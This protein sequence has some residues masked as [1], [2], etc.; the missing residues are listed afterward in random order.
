M[1]RAARKPA[2]K[3][4]PRDILQA[5]ADYEAWA[6]TRTPMIA[7]DLEH[8]HALMRA[9]R[10]S[11]FRA[12]F[13]RWAELWPFVCPD[14]ESGPH[15]L[16]VGDLHVENF[17]VWRDA[18]GRLV[19]GV[20]DF[21]EAWEAAFSVDLVRLLA[22]VIL[23]RETA[24]VRLKDEAVAELLRAGWLRAMTKD[25]APFVLSGRHKWLTRLAEGKLKDPRPFWKKME[26]LGPADP[27]EAA[28]APLAVSALQPQAE[29]VKLLH[30]I[31]GL[32]SLGH[33]RVVALGEWLGG[34]IAREAKALTPSAWIWA[35][36]GQAAGAPF[37]YRDILDQAIR[38]PDPTLA[39][40]EGW[41][42][43]RLAPDG[44]RVELADLPNR[45][46]DEKMFSAMGREIGAIHRNAPNAAAA[47]EQMEALTPLRL[48]EAAR[49]M[50]A[51]LETD[52]EQFKAG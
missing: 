28:G 27:L 45:R 15:L 39:D 6:A 37:R 14:L 42:V 48:V 23:A 8:K 24:D 4:Q 49:A 22:S 51:T 10:F 41:L 46:D 19:W 30:R 21:D 32:G 34:R 25:A 17:G 9:D 40:H 50:L 2:P 1:A 44:S 7:A 36:G 13:Y 12:T 16:C 11:F 18:E 33:P 31:A 3:A 38:C 20:N 43:R 35:R 26:R 47:V 29:E 5:T 52:F